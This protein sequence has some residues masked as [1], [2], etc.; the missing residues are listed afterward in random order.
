MHVRLAFSVAAHF[1]PEIMLVDEVLRVGDAEFQ[2]RCLGRMEDIGTSGR[3]V[4]FVSH[5]VQAIAQ[6]CDRVLLIDEGRIVRDGP[7][8][9]V[10]A[11]YLQSAT[12]TSSSQDVAD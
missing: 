11:H 9:E 4:L 12:G 7:S 10:V 5:Q 8:A 6:L 3:T 1:E 2:A